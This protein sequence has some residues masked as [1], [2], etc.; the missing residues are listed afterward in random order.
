MMVYLSWTKIGILRAQAK[1]LI[2]ARMYKGRTWKDP[3]MLQDSVSSPNLDVGGLHAR[4]FW[5]L[6]HNRRYSGPILGILCF[7][8]VVVSYF[9]LV[10]PGETYVTIWMND[11]LALLNGAYRVFQGQV[12]H[13]DFHVLHGPLVFYIP[14]LGLQAGLQ[15]SAVLAFNGVVI[16]GFLL[17]AGLL[18]MYRRIRLPLALMM[19]VFIWLLIVVPMGIGT[20]FRSIS[21]G[22][23]YNRHG[24]AAL[25]AIL[26]CY[27]SPEKP[28]PYDKW[29]DSVVLSSLTVFLIYTKI[30]FALVGAAFI[31][32][33]IVPNS[34][35]RVVSL[36]SIVVIALVMV[37]V[38]ILFEFHTAYF[39]NIFATT[40]STSLFRGG[41]WGLLETFITHAWIFLACVGALFATWVAG[42]RSW[43]DCAFMLS[44]VAASVLIFETNGG[45]ENGMPGLVIVF[46][47]CGELARR[48]ENSRKVN[49]KKNV[50]Q[51]HTGSLACMFLTLMFI[52][53]PLSNR[54]IAWHDHYVKTTRGTLMPLPGLPPA[55]S[56]FLVPEKT[57]DHQ[58]IYGHNKKG[59]EQLSRVRHRYRAPLSPQEYLLTIIE[60]LDILRTT[61]SEDDT[62]FVLDN[63]DPFSVALNL[64]PTKRGHPLL[65]ATPSMTQE[66]SLPGSEMFFDVD[67]VMVPAVP[68]NT[69]TFEV[70][71]GIYGDY[72]GRE[73]VE[74]KRS[75]H[76]SLLTRR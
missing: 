56:G 57:S 25:A 39:N 64:R 69:V 5:M 73:F 3:N 4:R 74:L 50:W 32:A 9:T 43:L 68:Y 59:H 31:V 10:L 26:L 75:P 40:E 49:S 58:D 2:V 65:W 30:T 36:I 20:G 23:Y 12:P 42:R 6:I 22:M 45:K 29:L 24:W 8:A 63:A 1:L 21:W 41:F 15:P 13:L 46:V 37:F 67:F 14:A 76:W 18:I 27:L 51:N 35:N 33:N 60:G 28:K 16:A 7:C 17:V 71:E 52:S 19:L 34:Y 53:E 48:A 72:L 61:V 11:T 44:V 62:L 54:I 47:C 38:E 55:L 70:M 66:N